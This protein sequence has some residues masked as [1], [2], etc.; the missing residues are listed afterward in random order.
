MDSNPNGMVLGSLAPRPVASPSMPNDDPQAQLFEEVNKDFE[1]IKRQKSRPSGGV[2]GTTLLNL[3]F[4]NDEPY[5]DYSKNMLSLEAKAANQFYL[6][7][8]LVA[9]RTNKLMGRLAAFNAPFKARPDKKDPQ[10]L[11]AAEVV[12]RMIVALDEKV[13]EPSRMREL[14]FWLMVGGVA[15]VYTPWVPNSNIEPMPV[16]DEQTGEAMWTYHAETGDTVVPQSY[17]QSVVEMGMEPPEAFEPFEEVQTVGEVGSFVYGPFNVFIDAKNRSIKDIGPGEWF[18]L[19]EIKTVS[20]VQE[21]YE[22][23]DDIHGEKNVSLVQSII[24]ADTAAATGTYLKDLVPMVQGTQDETD[25]DMVIHVMSWSPASSK[26]PRGKFVCWVPGQ[27]VVYSGDNPYEEIPCV[28]I[29]FVPATTSFWTRAY[30][31]PLLAPQR[32]IN[33]RMSQLGE[34]ANSSV[35]S[36]VLAAAGVS[37]DDI[38]TDTTKV[39]KNAVSPEGVP[40]L[41]RFPAHEVPAWF[42]ESIK[43]GIQMF[44]DAAGGADLMEDNKFPG[45]LRG[46]QAVPYLQEIM[47]TQWGPLFFHLGERLSTIK[48]QRLNRVKQ[49]YPESRTM[50]YTDR[51]QKDEVLVFH[52]EKIMRSGTNFS[53]SVDRGAIIPELRALREARLTERLRGPLAILYMDERTGKL[54]KSKIAA[55]LQFG[56][57]GRES[58]EAVYR[59]LALE[60]IKMLWEGKRVPP[61]QPFYDHKKML[62]ELEAAMATTEFMR[63]SQQI[64]QLFAGEWQQHTVFLQKEAAAQQSAMS[65]HAIHNAV[66]MATQ[67]AAAEAASNAVNDAMEQMRA[68]QEQPTEQFVA[69]AQSRNGYTAAAPPAKKPNRFGNTKPQPVRRTVT[70]EFGHGETSHSS[71]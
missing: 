36:Q 6:S 43:L 68:Q 49:F 70:E 17:M 40:L 38:G 50:H 52:A 5:V 45:Q 41:A 67:Q 1:R 8:N 16:L 35:Y 37:T 21:N 55:D 22:G 2:E 53:V 30:V 58:R 48:Q 20:W 47:D 71:E 42:V 25:P 59:K 7:F 63:A 65:S 69:G 34:M 19:A 46:P 12:D 15:V 66:A 24:N 32:F 13:E 64:Q 18:H 33:K 31:S 10:A 51:D 26:S 9:P 28:D 11:E 14:L 62:D 61:V 4:Y 23:T 29:H 39:I 44:N 3:C 60:R 54:D 56:D 57:T 27:R